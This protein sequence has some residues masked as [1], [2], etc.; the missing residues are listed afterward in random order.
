MGVTVV[1][2]GAG[3]I[4]SGNPIQ[5]VAERLSPTCHH[6]GGASSG[7]LEIR[8]PCSTSGQIDGHPGII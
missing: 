5:S 3:S 8:H 2:F 4:D 1:A 7:T 6:D